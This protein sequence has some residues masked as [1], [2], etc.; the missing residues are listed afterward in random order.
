[1][2]KWLKCLVVLVISV[3]FICGSQ[4]PVNAQEFSQ[5]YVSFYDYYDKVSRNC[6]LYFKTN[7]SGWS[8]ARISTPRSTAF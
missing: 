8:V 5:K 7:F 6:D 4:H 1:M 3:S 2:N